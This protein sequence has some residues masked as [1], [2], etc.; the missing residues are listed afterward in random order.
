MKTIVKYLPQPYIKI[1]LNDT[2]ITIIDKYKVDKLAS[3]I[4]IKKFL[5]VQFPGELRLN[6]PKRCTAVSA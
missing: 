4:H 2:P 6:I 3:F 1:Y 5:T